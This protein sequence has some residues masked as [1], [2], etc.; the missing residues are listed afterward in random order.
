MLQ[1][2][3][4]GHGCWKDTHDKAEQR[5]P[6][7]IVDTDAKNISLKEKRNMKQR[8]QKRKN[9]IPFDHKEM[10]KKFWS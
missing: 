9:K 5:Q 2:A 1:L 6:F 3:C 7:S 4:V 8:H 10:G